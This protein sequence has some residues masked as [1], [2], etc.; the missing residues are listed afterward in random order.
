M[1][2]TEPVSGPAIAFDER[3]RTPWWWYL[4]ALVVGALLAAEFFLA[5]HGVKVWL[6]YLVVLPIA[7][8]IVW[9][10][11]RDRIWVAGSEVHVRDAHLPLRFVESAVALDAATLRRVVGREGDPAAFTVIRPWIGPGVQIVLDDPDDPTPYWVS[12]TRHP[13]RLVEALRTGQ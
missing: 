11:G 3:L 2:L 8:A 10:I 6:P 1:R 4:V 12:S 9:W 13:D 7:L 5:D